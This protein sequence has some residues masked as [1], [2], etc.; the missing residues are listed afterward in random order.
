MGTRGPRRGGH[1]SA[2]RRAA[3]EC[4]ALGRD[5]T[6]LGPHMHAPLSLWFILA[7]TLVHTALCHLNPNS[8]VLG[9]LA[10]YKPLWGISFRLVIRRK[11]RFLCTSPGTLMH[12]QNAAGLHGAGNENP[13]RKSEGA[14]AKNLHRK[15]EHIFTYTAWSD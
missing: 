13:W 12:G 14:E 5:I 3:R 4:H 1:V 15:A 2:G 9:L 6:R 7:E 10:G 11:K 8:A